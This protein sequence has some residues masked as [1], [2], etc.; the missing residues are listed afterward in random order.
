MKK[1]LEILKLGIGYQKTIQKDI[2]ADLYAGQFICLIGPNGIGKSTF[3]KTI[4]NITPAI[5]GNIFLNDRDI[6][7]LSATEISK[8][9]GLVLTDP[10]E[11]FNL[12]A[13]DVVQ[14][15]RYPHTGFWGKLNQ[16]D[17][18]IIEEVVQEVNIKN[19]VD[20]HF[21]ELSDGEKQKVMIAKA[22]VQQAPLLL[23]DEPTAFLDFP[24]K[25]SLLV[26]LR[27][28]AKQ[29][30]IGIILSTHDIEL[31]LKTADQIWLFPEANKL[32]KGVPEDLVLE[33]HI[34]QVFHNDEMQFNQA[35][36]HFERIAKGNKSVN[37]QG[38]DTPM[39]WLS[40]ALQR[41]EIGI[42]EQSDIKVRFSDQF[43]IDAPNLK[44]TT[45]SNIEEVLC[46]LNQLL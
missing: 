14:M 29:N 8:T 40:R 6:K 41:N 24:T 4:A 13:I 23:L 25:A 5:S 42:S 34:N 38:D 19:L 2:S 7:S 28:L 12:K 36:G 32:I 35:S 45:Y 18:K 43:I 16:D 31:A 10:I 1:I 20:R 46:A 15:G 37:L 17:L 33:G 22:L 44:T 9:I 39:F 30:Q 21:S 26:M 3:L 11:G 27:N